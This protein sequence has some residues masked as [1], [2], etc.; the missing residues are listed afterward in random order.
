LT[1]VTRWNPDTMEF[2]VLETDEEGAN[3]ATVWDTSEAGNVISLHV[4]KV[5]VV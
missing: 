3:V 1:G 4:L 2:A 5:E